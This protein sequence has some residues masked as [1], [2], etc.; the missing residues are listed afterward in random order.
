MTKVLEWLLRRGYPAEDAFERLLRSVSRS[1][2]KTLRRYDFQKAVKAE[3]IGLSTPDIDFLFDLLA[4]NNRRYNV[5]QAMI[6]YKAGEATREQFEK[7]LAENNREATTE[8]KVE[9][10]LRKIRTVA[11]NPLDHIRKCVREGGHSES[12]L[13]HRLRHR[14]AFTM[15][16]PHPAAHEW[17][18]A[19]C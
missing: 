7:A 15:A 5:S 2:Q 10:W 4:G 6:A 16:G 3:E 13:M 18:A 14:V 17:A 8:L 9:H 19:T 1:Q 11:P 12:T